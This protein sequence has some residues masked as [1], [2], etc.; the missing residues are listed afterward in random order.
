MEGVHAGAAGQRV[1]GG[2]PPEHLVGRGADE[3]VRSRGADQGLRI[4]GRV[5]KVLPDETVLADI[6]QR[7]HQ[8]KDSRTFETIEIDFET[9]L[10][11]RLRQAR[12]PTVEGVAVEVVRQASDRNPDRVATRTSREV[13]DRVG[14]GV[15][16][17]IP[18]MERIRTGTTGQRV[19]AGQPSE[20]FTRCRADEHVRTCGTDEGLRIPGGVAAKVVRDQAGL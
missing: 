5:A 13:G 6:L 20:D 2:Q 12:M 15:F 10:G 14:R 17:R 9:R 18:H 19:V 16:W 3:R 7:R 4:P 8:P 11:T 1:V